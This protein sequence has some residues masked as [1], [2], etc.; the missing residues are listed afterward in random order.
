M[1]AELQKLQRLISSDQQMIGTAPVL[2][3]LRDQIATIAPTN[4]R[5]FIF[6]EN[7]SGKELVAREIHQQSKRVHQPFLKL[8]CAAVPSDL[9]ESELFGH[10]KGAF[11][12]AIR[13][14][15]GLF[16][17]A[18]NGTLFLDEIGDMSMEM[19]AKLLRVLQENEFLRVGGNQLLHFDVRIIA[20]T[21]KKIHDEIAAGNFREDLYYR[22]NVIPIQVPSLRER[23]TDIPLLARHFLTTY[24]L[25]NQLRNKQITTDAIQRLQ[26]YKWPGN[27]RELK[28]IMERL[29]IM[30]PDDTIT[31]GDIIRLFPESKTIIW[32]AGPNPLV[33][34]EN[35]SA[36]L[37]EQV[38]QF[39]RSLLSQK[40]LEVDGNVT[41]L[42]K[43]LKT[44]R[45][46]LHRKLKKYQIK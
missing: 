1:A 11:T 42:A 19:Q 9:I 7:G 6:G 18:G 38:E 2:Q 34:N 8:N 44:D 21:N 36:S 14:K 17:E 28:N 16:E 29:A 45:A 5:V 13:R 30:T 23:Q 35:I 31:V 46:N 37:R 32:N 4:S 41:Q 33:K 26:A 22:L 39:E 20:A 3:Q 25:K 24:C 27:I 15:L 12:G 10:E 40:Y 43:R